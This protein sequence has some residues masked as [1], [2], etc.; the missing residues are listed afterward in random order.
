[1]A[2]HIRLRACAAVAL[3]G[4]LFATPST[5]AASGREVVLA[6]DR[7]MAAL[8]PQS[9][10]A[11]LTIRELYHEYLN[12]LVLDGYAELESALGNGG[13]APL[14]PDPLRFNVRP[15]IEGEHPIGEKDLD[16]QANYVAARPATI[17]CLLDVAARVTSGP[18]EVTS[19]VRHS[20]YQDELR[21][22]NANAITAVPMHTM[23]LAFDIALVN[24]PFKT[25]LEIREVLE[26][27]RDAG[28]I[29]FIGERRQ[30]VFH[31]VPH[32]SRL[33]YFTDVYTRALAAPPTVPGA[34]AIPMLPLLDGP[35]VTPRR[36][37]V[38]A[39]V[40]N[41]RPTEDFATEW[42]AAVD[43][44]V[45]LA[46]RVMTAS[47]S[48]AAASVLPIPAN[49]TPAAAAVAFVTFGAI[50][51]IVRSR[52]FAR[53]HHTRSSRLLHP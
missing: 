10:E 28:D 22:T 19:L 47:P 48:V 26:Q 31:V 50:I 12:L 9:G 4:L 16:N 25:V 42:W 21:V 35:A 53:S 20:D 30:L 8:A 33:G 52:T 32:P 49:Y 17:G 38:S 41:V 29:L 45:D 43:P 15:R 11:S 34:H 24:T 3:G 44:D 39:E 40:I 51:A 14:P 18:L 36:A 46:A 6:I 5:A 27:M 13:L 7:M 2:Y 1:M 23:G 37:S